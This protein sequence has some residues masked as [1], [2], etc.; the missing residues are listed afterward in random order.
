MQPEN[1]SYCTK[2]AH[3]C[4]SVILNSLGEKYPNTGTGLKVYEFLVKAPFLPLLYRIILN[5]VWESTYP[6]N[7]PKRTKEC[8]LNEQRAE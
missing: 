6:Y 2:E 5:I 3:A 7:E 8:S 4:V 1:V